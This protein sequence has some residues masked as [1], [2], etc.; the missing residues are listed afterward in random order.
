[1]PAYS[2]SKAAIRAYGTSL[3]RWLGPRG[4]AVSVIVPGFVTSPMSRRHRGRK[5][6]EWPVDRAARRIA[7][8][9]ARREA[10]IA[11]PW[12]LVLLTWLGNRLPPGLGDR[13]MGLFAAE[14]E[15]DG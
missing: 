11:F 8:G 9:L 3:R 5:P 15:P 13:A 12:P 6:F 10:I 2:A 7:R 4:I 1:M 14:I